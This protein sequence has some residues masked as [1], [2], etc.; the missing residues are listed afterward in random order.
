MEWRKRGESFEHAGKFMCGSRHE[1]KDANDHSTT[2]L[3]HHSKQLSDSPGPAPNPLAALG[4]LLLTSSVIIVFP[5]SEI[6]GS[7]VVLFLIKKIANLFCQR[8]DREG[9]MQK[10]YFGV[11]DTVPNHDIVGIT[12]L[13]EHRQTRFSSP[14]H[15]S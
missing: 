13:E 14:K 5:V 3:L 12:A 8:V 11:Q 6:E 1:I 9:L 2:P 10:S 15:F 4:L 7:S